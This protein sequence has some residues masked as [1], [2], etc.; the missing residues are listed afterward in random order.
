MH[1]RWTIGRQ[2]GLRRVPE[3]LT[4]WPA[5]YGVS[6]GDG[7]F[8]E[9]RERHGDRCECRPLLASRRPSFPIR[10]PTRVLH[11]IYQLSRFPRAA[12]L[13]HGL[14]NAPD[15]ASCLPPP[16]VQKKT[17]T[18]VTFACP[19]RGHV[20]LVLPSAG[21]GM[22]KKCGPAESARWIRSCCKGIVTS[23]PQHGRQRNVSR[24]IS[25]LPVLKPATLCSF[26][27]LLL[28]DPLNPPACTGYAGSN[29]SR[30]NT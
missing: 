1:S 15:A 5:R 21:E 10:T 4:S 2:A 13:I 26:L 25:P 3:I 24:P 9:N 14:I 29:R 20:E 16:D 6:P 8:G 18:R 28:D 22:V 27:S 30:T 19:L 17:S 12:R 7:R 11:M 23:T